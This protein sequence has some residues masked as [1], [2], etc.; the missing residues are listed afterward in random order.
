VGVVLLATAGVLVL[1]LN[2]APPDVGFTAAPASP[3][4]G[5][6]AEDPAGSPAP[7]AGGGGLPVADGSIREQ[8]SA[9]APTLLRIPAIGVTATV[10]PVGINAA[11]GEFDV[12]PSVDEIGW[13][14]YGPGL[15]AVAGSIVIAGHVD[16]AN[17]GRGAFFRLR[18]VPIGAPIEVRGADGR[19]LTFRAAG[20]ETYPKS[21][22][23]LER[24]F[25]RDGAPRLTLIT[26]GGPF[27][28][29]TRSYRDNI[30]ITATPSP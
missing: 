5:T 13:Y 24:Y 29:Q 26:C 4:P 27:N 15:D 1:R 12:P 28:A 7:G 2:S 9:V 30:V 21:R 11:T 10:N 17:Q 25:A 18:D 23:P 20:R 22:I 6:S 3:A 16:G 19:T 14:S 8:G